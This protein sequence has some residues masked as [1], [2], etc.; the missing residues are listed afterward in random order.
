[1]LTYKVLEDLLGQK[2]T[3]MC[4][5]LSLDLQSNYTQKPRK[6]NTDKT[7]CIKV[8]VEVIFVSCKRDEVKVYSSWKH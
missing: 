3:N 5:Q 2:N 8:L 7:T 1:M 6:E 4:P